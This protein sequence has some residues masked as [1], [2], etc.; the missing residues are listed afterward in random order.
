MRLRIWYPESEP[1]CYVK[2]SGLPN[3]LAGKVVPLL[4]RT[5]GGDLVFPKH[6]GDLSDCGIPTIQG[7]RILESGCWTSLTDLSLL[8]SLGIIHHGLVIRN[9]AP[10]AWMPL[11]TA[12][13][14]NLKLEA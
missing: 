5:E 6:P 3:T 1:R 13:P 9:I 11:A 14:L 12:A 7:S 2:P 8:H 4:G 10:N